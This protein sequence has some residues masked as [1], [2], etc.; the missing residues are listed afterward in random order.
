MVVAL[1]QSPGFPRLRFPSVVACVS[2]LR[3]NPTSGAGRVVFGATA[4]R[5]RA[6][7]WRRAC[8]RTCA[9]HGRCPETAISHASTR[10]SSSR[11]SLPPSAAPSGP[12]KCMMTKTLSESRGRSP[13]KR[14]RESLRIRAH[15]HHRALL[16]VE[17][18]AESFEVTGRALSHTMPRRVRTRSPLVSIRRWPRSAIR[19]DSLPGSFPRRCPVATSAPI[20]DCGYVRWS[21]AACSLGTKWVRAR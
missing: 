18:R 14:A 6:V 19:S 4:Q 9:A 5:L 13:R 10:S 11:R 12:S 1:D 2:K 17:A 3:A 7:E 21:S 8:G 16:F 15:A 20:G